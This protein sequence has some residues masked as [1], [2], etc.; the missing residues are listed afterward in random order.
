M[1]QVA[2]TLRMIKRGDIIIVAL[3]MLSSFIPLGVFSYQQAMAA[4]S[5]LQVVVEVDGEVI[6]T[7]DLLDDGKTET[8]VYTDDHGHENTIVREGLSVRMAE[9]SCNDQVCVKMNPIDA[10]GETILCLPHRV[11]VE[12][13]STN[14]EQTEPNDIDVLS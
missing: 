7:F 6:H 12:V 1:K 10:A 3:L 13:R 8:F 2:K 14:G 11:L 9:A 4:G 5:A